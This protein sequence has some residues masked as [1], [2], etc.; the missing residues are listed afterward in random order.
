[1]IRRGAKRCS[2]TFIMR[3]CYLLVMQLTV[4]IPDSVAE[5]LTASG[6]DLTRT[7]LEAIALQGYRNRTL[8]EEMVRS[9]LGFEIRYEVHQF[10]MQ[11][12]VP[13][14]YSVE[15]WEK[16]KALADRNFAER[17]QQKHAALPVA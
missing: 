15:D 9:L 14:N 2:M 8:S 1:M 6:A 13:L 17:Q 16:D 11:H 4:E 10:L 3:Q 7:A 5:H 12:G